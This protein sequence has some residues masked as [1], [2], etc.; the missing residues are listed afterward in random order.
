MTPERW[1]EIKAMLAAVLE[2]PAEER[3]TFLDQAC[4]GD[5]SL[6]AEVESLIA[7]EQAEDELDSSVF[8]AGRHLKSLLSSESAE[9]PLHILTAQAN[10][11]IG[12]YK[13]IREI[14]R[15]GMGAVYL[16]E[17]ADDQYRRQVAI[18]LIR[19]DMDTD[20]VLRRFRNERQILAALD[21]VN[22]A[23]LF[24]G[25]TTEDGLPY[26]VMEYI[27]GLPIN[28]YCDQHELNIKERLE[29]FHK[30]CGAIHYAHQRQVIHRDIKPSNILV[31][32]EGVP[33]LL[34]FGIAK[35]LTPELAAQTLDPTVTGLHLMT[36]AYASPE[37]VKGEPITVASDVYSLGVLLYEL[38][39]GHKPYRVRN[40]LELARAVVEEEPARPSTA[41]SLTEEVPGAGSSPITITP[42]SVSK[43]REATPERLVKRLRGDLDNILLMALRKDPQRRYASVED[44]SADIRAHLENRPVKARKDS[45]VYRANKFVRRK[46][47]V[48]PLV[49][50][51]ILVGV[52]GL[53]A[54]VWISRNSKPPG[55]DLKLQSIAVLPF[56]TD[57]GDEYLG[58]GIA[59]TIASALTNSKQITVRP[60]RASLKYPSMSQS[61][62]DAGHA[63]QVDAILEGSVTR[64][65]DQ[66]KI[67]AQL[68]RVQD[69]SRLWQSSDRL[70]PLLAV[71][72]S[73]STE[74]ARAT[75]PELSETE[76]TLIARR[77]T[78]S[79][80]AYNLYLQAR[81]F[82]NRRKPKELQYAIERFE[83][84]I[85][86]DP[87]YAQAY[88][89]LA[90]AYILG[91]NQLAAIERMQKAKAAAQKALEIDNTLSEA[92]MA[93]GRALIFCDWD[94][95]GSEKA[96][97]R[98]IELTPNYPDAHYW[99]SH[100]L[101]AVGRHDEA[102][103][104]LKLAF[105]IDPFL[106]RTVLQ[107][108]HAFYLARQYDRAIEQ[109][110]RTPFDVD[111][112][113]YQ[114]YWRLGL[115]YAQK[116]LYADAIPMLQK[117]QT[118]SEEM[119]LGKA[120]L[121]YVYAKSGNAAEAR[122]VLSEIRA[123]TRESP[124]LMLAGAYCYLGESDKA[125]E[126][127]EKLYEAHDAPIMFIK[128]DPMLDNI[129]DDPRYKDLLR[130]MG[131]ASKG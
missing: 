33:K 102:I 17:R 66:V 42:D 112:T 106:P 64:V 97:K 124:W 14:A 7:E 63:L 62:V 117:A 67:N 84:A 16:A 94:W 88:A 48:A 29:L 28:A 39:T 70:E 101:T 18:K 85:K 107:Q 8:S 54:Y 53:L 25:G 130:R 122:K 3:A 20:F 127:L 46:Y 34:D 74:V 32:K 99:Y 24:D 125:I 1:Q 73:I 58:D 71:E 129:R 19:R 75:R 126:C 56:K 22:I 98:A 83:Q 110:L 65:G 79:V 91:I 103:A 2:R 114:V 27:E 21:H 100:N 108:G 95:A 78:K 128:V 68:V 92:H 43:V 109:F 120:S 47:G 131:L 13:I 52:I 76:R 51:L 121:A 12:A 82:F 30:A 123:S 35:L 113:Y 61:A 23:R 57:A 89:G 55:A 80:E 44:F 111:A 118:F 60:V 86:I 119:S 38:L 77:N 11:R 96:F 87:T 6:R 105:D 9:A 45:I 5:G 26:L 40:Q 69:G 36:P 93:L 59:D 15:G 116:G 90:H 81:H 115:A 72:D 50:S 41:I 49:V 31:T 104:E 4:D 37:Q 10:Q